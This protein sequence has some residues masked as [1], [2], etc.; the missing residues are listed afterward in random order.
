MKHINKWFFLKNTL[1]ALL[2][3]GFTFAQTEVKFNT[4]TALLLIPNAGVEFQLG[5]RGSFQLDGLVSFWDSFDGKPLHIVQIFPEYRRYSKPNMRGWFVGIHMGFGMFTLTKYGYPDHAY[6]SGR[7]T[8]YGLSIGYKK[9][10][11]ENWAIEAFLGGGNQ[12]AH[13]RGYDSNTRTRVDIKPDENRMFNLSGE[14]IPYRGGFM[15]VYK[16][17]TFAKAKKHD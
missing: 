7:N 13:Y 14:W 8:Y 10:L 11:G 2:F 17:P 1:L 9:S 12:H 4:A 3:T 5:A 15:I 6:Q 16:I